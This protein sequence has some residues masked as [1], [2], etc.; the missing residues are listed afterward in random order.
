MH[1]NNFIQ[2]GI[3]IGSYLQL[4]DRKALSQGYGHNNDRVKWTPSVNDHA[5][6]LLL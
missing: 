3:V 6:E 4:N 5:G 2:C 1:T